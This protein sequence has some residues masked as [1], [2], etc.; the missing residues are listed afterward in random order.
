VFKSVNSGGSWTR[1]YTAAVPGN[2]ILDLVVDPQVPGILY[3]AP[4]GEPPLRSV[5]G[6][7][8]WERLRSIIAGSNSRVTFLALLPQQPSVVVAAK[9]HAGL[10][11]MRILPD[12]RFT[13]PNPELYVNTRQT[14]DLS[15]RNFGENSAVRLRLTATL[16]TSSDNYSVVTNV[17]G[18]SQSGR[19]L[20]CAFDVLRP[21]EV[22]NVTVAFTPAN[23]REDLQASVVAYGS[24]PGVFDTVA[25]MRTIRRINLQT[26]LVS[27]VTSAA[28]GAP[29]A[30]TMTVGNSGPSPALDVIANM[31][32]PANVTFVSTTSTGATCAPSGQ[33]VRCETPSIGIGATFQA[34]VTVTAAAAGTAT[35]NATAQAPADAVEVD[36]RNDFAT[37]DVIVQ[38]SSSP[39]PQGG[40]T[41]NVSGGG[42][43]AAG[44]ELLLL[45]GIVGLIRRH[46]RRAEDARVMR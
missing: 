21:G 17:S 10:H 25:Q 15:F 33:V 32:L 26:S 37:V 11:E 46:L 2:N 23:I 30:Y 27:D 43:G 9:E 5:D 6:G 13:N 19:D 38:G 12:L 18:C 36:P 40:G 4:F 34:R 42:G 1:I 3:A 8:T 44:G 41:S 29:I 31:V 28:I 7:A 16:P 22:A 39:P 14:A 35:T 45:L 24:V 20:T